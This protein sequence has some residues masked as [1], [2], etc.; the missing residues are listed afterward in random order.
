MFYYLAKSLASICFNILNFLLGG[1]LP[2]FGCVCVIVE[3][4]QQFLLLEQP[5]GVLAFPGGFM[6]WRETPEQALIREGREETGLELRLHDL[7]G[8]LPATSQGF[9]QMSTVTFIYHGEIIGGNLRSSS[10][11]HPL[12]L[13]ADEL[14]K[15]LSPYFQL[16]LE[17][18]LRHRATHSEVSR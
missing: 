15:K 1:N 14:P 17:Q 12:W 16:M 10:E 5:G 18:Y 6:K 2:P 7:V 11:G 8:F 4:E 13:P 9:H 3:K